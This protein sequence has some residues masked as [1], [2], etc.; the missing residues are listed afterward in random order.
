MRHFDFGTEGAVLMGQDETMRKI[1]LDIE[2]LPPE[3]NNFVAVAD[4]ENCDDEK[5]KKLALKA[6]KG[7]LL[8][9][10]VTVE[11][12]NRVVRQGLFGRDR[13]T[14]L[15][16]LD[17]AKMLRAFWNFVG[18]F[19]EG[20]DLFV[21]HNIL[22]FDLPFL[23]KRSIVHRIKPAKIS[24]AR[25]RQSPIFDTMWEWSLWRERISLND[26]AEAVGI[27]SPKNGGINGSQIYDYFCAGKHEEIALYCMRDVEC[28]REIYY[29]ISFLDAP[30]LKPYQ[31]EQ[32]FN[33]IATTTE[34][35]LAA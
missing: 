32:N 22:D 17:E 4:L 15:F 33:D 30:Q 1:F 13:Q 19:V 6:E 9:I 34:I 26:V 3:K 31:I 11:E 2:T 12:N 28:A 7:R 20:K 18:A 8:T 10:G 29:R 35:A 16:H 27:A 25:F 5:F 21:G 23:I 14:G 24:F